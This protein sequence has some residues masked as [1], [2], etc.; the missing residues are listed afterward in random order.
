LLI[1]EKRRS[2]VAVQVALSRASGQ[3]G[4]LCRI[5]VAFPDIGFCFV[6]RQGFLRYPNEKPF[7]F[8][9][10]SAVTAADQ[11]NH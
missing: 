10:R 7:P 6:E 2:V 8:F 9:D 5:A 1:V 3:A 4:R 11:S